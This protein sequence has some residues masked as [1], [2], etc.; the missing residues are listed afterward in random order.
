[1]GVFITILVFGFPIVFL[2][3]A[4]CSMVVRGSFVGGFVLMSILI[5]CIFVI[6][7]TLFKDK[8]KER[9][10]NENIQKKNIEFQNTVRNSH[11]KYFWLN[12][13]VNLL[14]FDAKGHNGLSGYVIEHCTASGYNKTIMFEQIQSCIIYK[15]RNVV[16]KI[17]RNGNDVK[18]RSV[19]LKYAIE[20][21]SNDKFIF[22]QTEDV[23]VLEQIFN[24]TEYVIT[25][26]RS[27][28]TSPFSK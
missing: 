8:K 14:L 18:P 21:Q 28:E 16:K 15:G 5:S 9:Q 2:F 13:G 12:N 19:S 24:I 27:M 17:S 20:I 10:Y 22:L 25:K 11:G 7:L 6:N 3:W 26:G 1:M 23:S 4:C